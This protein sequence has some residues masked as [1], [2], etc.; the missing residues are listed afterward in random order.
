MSVDMA[1]VERQAPELVSV[2]KAA[3]V[4]MEKKGLTDHTAR[5][6]LVMDTSGSMDGRYRNGSVQQMAE[7][8]LVLGL[9]FDDN[10][11]VEIIGFD[12]VATTMGEMD[13]DNF[14]S[15]FSG[16]NLG[17]GTSYAR[18]MNAVRAIIEEDKTTMPCYVMFVTDGQPQDP[19]PT[20]DAL[21][22][23]ST[24]PIFWQFMAVGGDD[25]DFS[26]LQ[27]L[28]TLDGRRIDNANFF[29]VKD[30]KSLTDDQFFAKMM[31]EYPLWIDGAK[32]IGIL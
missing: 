1:K 12:E 4:N 11:A 5:V 23:S 17:Y 13:L 10:G 7:R 32:A 22:A 31:A 9:N 25:D 15:M 28:D 18:A 16:V 19:Q 26:F 14:R 29:A 20:R 21:I 30:P 27:S 24:E 6:F 8:A 3:Q 2:V